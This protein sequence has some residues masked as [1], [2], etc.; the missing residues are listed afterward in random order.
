MRYWKY[1]ERRVTKKLVAEGARAKREAK[2]WPISSLLL[3]EV[4]F[5]YSFVAAPS[6]SSHFL[7]S[8]VDSVRVLEPYYGKKN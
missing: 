5:R 3:F 1:R 8:K 7:A 4:A 6:K 2:K